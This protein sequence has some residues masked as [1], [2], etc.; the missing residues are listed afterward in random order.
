M[1]LLQ[2][3]RADVEF[4]R[5]PGGSR[6]VLAQTEF[7]D[8]FLRRVEFALLLVIVEDARRRVE[9]LGICLLLCLRF[10]Q[11]LSQAVRLRQQIEI[12]LDQLRRPQRMER[13]F[14]DGEPLLKRSLP[15]FDERPRFYRKNLVGGKFFMIL[16]DEL[17]RGGKIRRAKT[18]AGIAPANCGTAPRKLP[19]AV[20]ASGSRRK[21][22]RT[23]ARSA[24]RRQA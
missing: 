16:G 9:I 24:A 13:F 5:A 2:Q 17:R 22:V 1:D 14:I 15:V 10:I 19:P 8:G 20:P 7:G 6:A 18:L 23:H 4:L 11:E 21:C 12:A 3:P